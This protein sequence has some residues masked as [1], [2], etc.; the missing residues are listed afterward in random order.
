MKSAR[1]SKAVFV[2]AAGKLVSDVRSTSDNG[3]AFAVTNGRGPRG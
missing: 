3:L 1:L 2:D